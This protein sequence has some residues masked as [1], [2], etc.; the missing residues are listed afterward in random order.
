MSIWGLWRLTGYFERYSSNYFWIYPYVKRGVMQT[1]DA[2]SNR[3]SIRS[4]TGEPVS[5]EELDKIIHAA[6]SAPVVMADYNNCIL[7]VVQ[8]PEVLGLIEDAG[9]AL[10]NSDAMPHP[11]YGAPTL[12]LVSMR[13]YPGR[14]AAMFASAGAIVQ[15]MSI[16]ATDLK[17]GS[18]W[19]WASVTA[20]QG[21]RDIYERLGLPEGFTPCGSIILGRAEEPVGEP[22]DLGNPI[23]MMVI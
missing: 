10:F 17:I 20:V 19:I 18:C 2:I 6:Q 3:K 16:A 21:H 9:R 15:N 4:F 11:L 13:I 7:T 5:Q 22:R 12:I 1:L 14:E 23:Q 8:D